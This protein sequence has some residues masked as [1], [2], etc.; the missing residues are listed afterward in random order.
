MA[1][2]ADRSAPTIRDPLRIH[3][4]KNC[5]KRYFMTVIKVVMVLQCDYTDTRSRGWHFG[6]LYAERSNVDEI[7][8]T[9]MRGGTSK[10]WVFEADALTAASTRGV[11]ATLLRLFGSPDPRQIDGVGGGTSTTSKA[12]ILSPSTSADAD[13]DYT[14]AQVGIDEAKVDWGSNCGNC[15]AVVAPYAVRRG[16]VTVQDGMTTVRVRNTNTSQLIIQ[17]V[18]TPGATLPESGTARIPGVPFPGIPVRMGFLDPAGRTTG[19]LY[20][21]GKA[22]DELITAA[23]VVRATLIDAGAPVVILD[24][25]EVGLTGA[26]PAVA[27]DA[28]PE[29]LARLDTI[30][31]AAAVAMGLAQSPETAA[32][33]IPKLALVSPAI[34]GDEAAFQV[35]M[36]SMGRVHPALAITGSVALSLAA[37]DLATVVGPMVRQPV[38]DELTMLTPAGAL[39]TWFGEHRGHPVVGAVRTA[40]RLAESVLLLP[41]D[42]PLA[43]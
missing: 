11:D 27:I 43:G 40:R 12:V 30:R 10:C 3:L 42:Q 4:D 20:P 9:W 26:E 8:A 41:D 32:R 16:W 37:K 28:R 21:T 23:G 38:G 19:L 14:F 15:S 39:T 36:L 1:L 35:R 2:G 25:R 6:H 18:A 29:L 13:V 22:T 7:P 17:Q 33:A 31:R 34:E 5:L 24:A